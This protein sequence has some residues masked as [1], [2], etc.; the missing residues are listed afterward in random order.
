MRLGKSENGRYGEQNLLSRPTIN[1]ADVS[2]KTCLVC[3]SYGKLLRCAECQQAYYCNKDH[4]IQHW[5]YH[6]PV[7]KKKVPG[8]A[9]SR[10]SSAL[11]TATL[12]ATAVP[13]DTKLQI[14]Q[15][16]HT[17][18][19]PHLKF[20]KLPEC[21]PLECNCRVKECNMKSK[22][23]SV[24]CDLH[25]VLVNEYRTSEDH[26]DSDD[27]DRT[28]TPDP[29]QEAT[30][31]KGYSVSWL[32]SICDILV[33][34]MNSHGICVI[35]NFLG[36]AKG[37]GCLRE[38]CRLYETGVFQAGKLIKRIDQPSENIRGDF[39]TWINGTEPNCENISIFIKILDAVIKKVNK[40]P[41][42]GQF[43]NYELSKRTEVYLSLQF[44]LQ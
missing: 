35:D 31:S 32:N 11:V 27:I 6:K 18:T 34:D 39:I 7:C 26:H 37:E 21:Q 36:S 5:K 20:D 15:S 16:V 1:M 10:S 28:R 9:E 8:I 12:A 19:L 42:S 40:Q 4:Q 23:H 13:S 24:A 33:K 29:L 22:K 44:V 2:A 30:S 41:N 3:G 17:E 38:V 25:S 43:K 14:A